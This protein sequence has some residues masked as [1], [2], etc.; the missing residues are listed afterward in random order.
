MKALDLLSVCAFH[1]PVKS[2]AEIDKVNLLL[3]GLR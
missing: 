2:Q 1:A 3:A